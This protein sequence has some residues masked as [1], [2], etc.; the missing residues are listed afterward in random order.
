MNKFLFYFLPL[1]F[2]STFSIAQLS[3]SLTPQGQCFTTGNTTT[4]VVT[5]SPPG[6]TSFSW[7]V[8]PS[9]SICTAGN[10]ITVINPTMAV[11]SFG[12]CGNKQINCFA[13]NS[14][15]TQI[16]STAVSLTLT[17]NSAFVASSSPGLVCPGG[18]TTALSASGAGT[19]TWS[20]G[21][22]GS[23]AI[24]S[25][26]SSTVF[27]V[28]GTFGT[29]CT[30]TQTVAV[31]VFTPN[32]Q[33]TPPSA[34]ICSGASV[35]LTASGANSYTWTSGT[36][37][38]STFPNLVVSP[39][40]NTIYTVA[41]TSV[42]NS[43]SCSSTTT[44][45]V[46]VSSAP[47]ISASSTPTVACP[48]ATVSLAAFGTSTFTW[49]T[50]QQGSVVTVTI[51]PVA[52]QASYA[53]VGSSGACPS[54]TLTLNV[55]V[56]PAPSITV[57]SSY[58]TSACEGDNV[59]LAAC[60]AST[61]TWSNNVIASS[62]TL[63]AVNGINYSVTGTGTNGCKNTVTYN[64][65]ATPLPTI[66]VISSK[67]MACSAE[68]VTLT[69]SGAQ[70]Y[71]WG[72]LSNTWSNLSGS[73]SVTL[74]AI[75]GIYFINGQSTNS[76]VNTATYNL[77]V[78]PSPTITATSSKTFVCKGEK[79]TLTPNGGT[80]YTWSPVAGSGTLILTPTVTTNYGLIGE[81][82]SGCTNTAAVTVTVDKCQ[83]LGETEIETEIKFYPNP[84]FNELV[85]ESPEPA[86]VI[87]SN[88]SG[89]ILC[90]KAL[91]EK[92]NVIDISALSTGYY[93]ITLRSSSLVKKSKF[94][95]Q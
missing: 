17:C 71:T 67:S 27:T 64:I 89:Q 29:G 28:T 13:Y 52:G 58:F 44:V 47:T 48:G 34:T 73:S 37:P 8:G 85:I 75:S 41:A 32:L 23:Q 83:G 26:L 30:N 35:N 66:T 21:T 95:K 57:V 20:N 9:I 25:V 45:A 90:T 84:G 93:F 92:V 6:T 1:I 82:T 81:N 39:L 2:F 49:S 76:C 3:V 78:T 11:F 79:I 55:S 43:A 63:T 86:T 53:V 10:T 12:C 40:I 14:S 50:L 74:N 36:G 61:Y 42:S 7:S 24:A 33:I 87:I 54:N 88:G 5:N 70:S 15:N 51:P 18:G 19:Y 31:N 46:F 77:I 94:V 38:P 4:V 65:V 80:S 72:A 59:T 91:H 22:I 56:L 16:G 62:I 68:I 69:A 60:C